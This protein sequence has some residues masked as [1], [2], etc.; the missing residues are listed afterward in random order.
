MIMFG[1]IIEK[2]MVALFGGMNHHELAFIF[3]H[4]HSHFQTK[5]GDSKSYELLEHF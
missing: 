2:I 3:L 4:Y 1:A 5:F